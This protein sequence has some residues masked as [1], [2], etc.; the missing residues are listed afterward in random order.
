METKVRSVWIGAALLLCAPAVFAD[1]GGLMRTPSG[2]LLKTGDLQSRFI[3]EL[4]QPN[5]VRELRFPKTKPRGSEAIPNYGEV[6]GSNQGEQWVY[7]LGGRNPKM[8]I[9]HFR[10]HVSL[11]L[12]QH[13]R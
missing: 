10:G 13:L 11:R 5:L 4:G 7:Q 3:Q 9:V 12:C 6:K 2:A 1:C 8:V